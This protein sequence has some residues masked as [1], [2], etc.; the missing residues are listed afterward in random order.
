MEEFP[1]LIPSEV[2]NIPFP[3][4]LLTKSFPYFLQFHNEKMPDIL[5]GSLIP[6]LMIEN[7]EYILKL[8]METFIA[9]N[10]H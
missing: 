3:G 4:L 8:P 2:S 1:P 9:Y 6:G 5:D 7:Y 10:W